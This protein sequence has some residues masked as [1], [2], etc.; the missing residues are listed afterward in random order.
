MF[1]NELTYGFGGWD[2]TGVVV[3]RLLAATVFG[4]LIGIERETAGKSAGVRTHMLVTLGTALFVIVCQRAGFGSD[5]LSRVIQGIVTG[6]GFI[7]AGSIIKLSEAREVKGLTTS[8]G[9]WM[10]AAIGISVGLGA[11]GLAAAATVLSLLILTFAVLI[12]NWVD[13]AAVARK[14]FVHERGAKDDA[15]RTV[16]TDED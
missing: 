7:G 14:R 2:G 13:R 8:A 4:A 11:V 15:G 16:P 12:D 3:I 6:I 5:A 1:W 10:A 9:V